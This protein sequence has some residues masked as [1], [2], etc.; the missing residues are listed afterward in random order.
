MT[1]YSKRAAFKRAP[2]AAACAVLIVAGAV[3]A[4]QLDPLSKAAAT[5]AVL[6]TVTV[7]GIQAAIESAISVKKGADTIVEAISSEDIGKLPDPSVAD[8]LSRLP[9][10]SA[11]RNKDSGFRPGP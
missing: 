5:Q 6:G 1:N 10:V 11:Q 7:T 2:V 3:H 4:Q 8:S 9:G